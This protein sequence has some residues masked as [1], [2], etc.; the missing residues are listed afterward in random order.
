[1]PKALLCPREIEV[2]PCIYE[3]IMKTTSTFI[4]SLIFVLG[5]CSLLQAQA[6]RKYDKAKCD[7]KLNYANHVKPTN[8][9]GGK[10]YSASTFWA[11]YNQVCDDIQSDPSAW[12]PAAES[13]NSNF[14]WCPGCT[15]TA[16]GCNF[17]IVKKAKQGGGGGTEFRG[18]YQNTSSGYV[19]NELHLRYRCT[20][21]DSAQANA[22]CSINDIYPNP[23]SGQ[24]NVIF[25]LN[26]P[27]GDVRIRVSD[28]GGMPVQEEMYGPMMEG[29]YSDEFNITMSQPGQYF[30]HLMVNGM[31]EHSEMVMKY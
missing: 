15:G 13:N 31:I 2:G 29:T 30:V 27:A 19:V 14:K 25:T 1:M 4:L 12:K 9:P 18:G 23:N 17:Q 6:P 21:C 5:S 20:T 8:H 7:N 16:T 22:C 26:Q 24:F 3:S 28:M 10:G 11:F